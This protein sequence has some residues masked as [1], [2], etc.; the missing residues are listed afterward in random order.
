MRITVLK[1]LNETRSVNNEGLG[2]DQ[3]A[4]CSSNWLVDKQRFVGKSNHFPRLR[5][6]GE[7]LAA[8]QFHDT[9][10]KA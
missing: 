3:I 8:N 7:S 2:G 6:E 1:D 4:H 10:N 9:N 5:I